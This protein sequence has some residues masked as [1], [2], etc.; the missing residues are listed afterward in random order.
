M[1]LRCKGA[2]DHTRCE[3]M[4]ALNQKIH[5]S[6][7]DIYVRSQIDSQI[8]LSRKTTLYAWFMCHREFAT[9]TLHI[10]FNTV[11]LFM[12]FNPGSGSNW[13]KSWFCCVS[14]CL[15]WHCLV[16][17]R[18]IS[19]TNSL[20]HG[21]NFTVIVK[22]GG[23]RG[24]REPQNRTEIRQKTTNRIGFFPNTE[25]A[26]TWRPQYESWRQ[27]DSWYILITLYVNIKL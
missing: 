3:N 6:N 4:S 21:D 7:T 12:L 13:V 16:T 14:F 20:F 11:I 24:I 2:P 9:T 25:T 15:E 23:V 22:E 10:H 27:Q 17:S 5:E 1:R 18:Q 19:W 8:S 26:R